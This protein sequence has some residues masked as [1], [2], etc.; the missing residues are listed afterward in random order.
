MRLLCHVRS[1]THILVGGIGAAPDKGRRNLIDELVFGVFHLG[2]QLR[3]RAGAVWRV[4]PDDV[5]LQLGEIDLYDAVKIIAWIGVDLFVGHE[6][7][8][9]LVSQLRQLASAS[10]GEV[11]CHALVVWEY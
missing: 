3:D 5:R 9:V 1:A 6:E 2:S 10:S 11:S 8:A 7:V 4:W